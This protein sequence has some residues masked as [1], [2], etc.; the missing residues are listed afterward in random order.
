MNNWEIPITVES[1]QTLAFNQIK[2][3][4]ILTGRGK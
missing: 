4:T 3:M 1:I 2:K